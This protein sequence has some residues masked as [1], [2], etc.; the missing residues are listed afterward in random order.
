[1]ALK[2]VKG[3]GQVEI[4]PDGASDFD[5]HK[6]FLVGMYL[7]EIELQPSA[8]SDTAKVRR[9]CAMGPVIARLKGGGKASFSLALEHPYIAAA[10]CK[11]KNPAG[12]KII[13]RYG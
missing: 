13:L 6:E 4:T 8:P 2:I 7:T 5:P 10:D 9:G 3:G 12:A 11:F 1:M